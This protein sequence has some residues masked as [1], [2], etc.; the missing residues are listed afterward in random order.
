MP[1]KTSS[2]KWKWG[3][4]ERNS[5]KEL[6]QT[7]YGI[8]KKNGSKGSFSDFLKGTNESILNASKKDW[9]HGTNLPPKEL[10]V[11]PPSCSKLFWITTE[12]KYAEK[13]KSEYRNMKFGSIYKILLK[14]RINVFDPKNDL[15]V[16]KLKWPKYF[17]FWLK[18]KDD[19]LDACSE[20]ISKNDWDKKYKDFVKG[21]SHTETE[22]RLGKYVYRAK[23]SNKEA[24]KDI[25]EWDVFL[26]TKLSY[27][28]FIPSKFKNYYAHDNRPDGFVRTKLCEELKKLGYQ[29]IK[30][31]EYGYDT[32]GIFDIDALDKISYMPID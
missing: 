10:K 3:N 26:N 24:E 31:K 25:L 5:K 16:E 30:S 19:I 20:V 8:W 13:F 22:N 32:L 2:G 1:F 4:V 7:V 6:V 15:E 29:A 21:A 23:I 12:K 14:D 28:K 11:N 27:D 9:Y 17:K 18:F